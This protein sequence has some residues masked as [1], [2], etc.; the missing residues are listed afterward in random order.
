MAS[1]ENF[2]DISFIEDTTIED[3]LT[4]M[5][6]DYQER[7][8]EITGKE[9]SLAA[10][11]PYRLILYACASQIYQVMQYADHAGKM[12]FLKYATGDYLD[13]L[14]ALRGLERIEAKAA[15]TTL[16]FAIS[17]PIQSAVSIPMGCR[18][19]NGNDVFFAT[20]EY[21]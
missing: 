14:A 2:P 9:V 7:Y 15:V 3:V 11:N 4:Q 17:S 6:N 18:V 10:A 5:I 1:I 13:S 12:S 16:Q 20:D 8:A 19:T 21:V